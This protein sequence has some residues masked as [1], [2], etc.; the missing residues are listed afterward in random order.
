MIGWLSCKY[1]SATINGQ[2]GLWY[3]SN[4]SCGVYIINSCDIMG[5]IKPHNPP[6][7]FVKW[8]TTWL[9]AI[10]Y[11]FTNIVSEWWTSWNW[12]ATHATMNNRYVCE[13]YFLKWAQNPK[14]SDK[15]TTKRD[16]NVFQCNY[17]Q[18]SFCIGQPVQ[19]VG[20]NSMLKYSIRNKSKMTTTNLKLNLF[21]TKNMLYFKFYYKVKNIK[22][23][24]IMNPGNSG[25][26]IEHSGNS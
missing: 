14:V 18:A 10:K 7:E 22:V 4:C 1:V 19:T 24:E 21:I 13:K 20:M 17:C 26:K 25:L 11:P 6:F 2:D 23:F 9:M 5:Y 3:T 8:H 12:K 16:K 15:D